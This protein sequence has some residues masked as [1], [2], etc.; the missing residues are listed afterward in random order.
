MSKKAGEGYNYLM[1]KLWGENTRNSNSASYSSYSSQSSD[2]YNNDKQSSYVKLGDN[3][4][5]N[6]LDDNYNY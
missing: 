4:N 6:L 5:A 3:K 2:N 1:G